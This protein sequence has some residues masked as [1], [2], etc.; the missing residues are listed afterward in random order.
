M[1]KPPID[2]MM[3]RVQWTPIPGADG[4]EIG[5]MPYATHVGI[6]EIGPCRIECARLSNGQRVITEAGL[7]QLMEWMGLS[8]EERGE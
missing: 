2:L 1:T 8:P 5:E 6:L 4:V 7:R 3:D